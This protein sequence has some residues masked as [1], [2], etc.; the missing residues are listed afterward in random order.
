MPVERP[1]SV[2]CGC[3]FQDQSSRRAAA[4]PAGDTQDVPSET[5]RC[6]RLG[7]LPKRFHP[8]LAAS[9]DPWPAVSNPA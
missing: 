9:A 7:R 6:V 2:A 8:L 3:L 1:S 4:L 5:D